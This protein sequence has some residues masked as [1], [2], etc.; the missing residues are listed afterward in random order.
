VPRE[1]LDPPRIYLLVSITG[2]GPGS[3]DDEC[4]WLIG[5]V[6]DHVIDQWWK[7]AY[8]RSRPGRNAD[9]WMRKWLRLP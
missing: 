4:A 6:R 9:W 1:N 8:R 2:K 5:N 3:V 7:E